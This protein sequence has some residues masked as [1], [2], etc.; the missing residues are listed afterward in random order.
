MK[1]IKSFF[2]IFLILLLSI[3]MFPGFYAVKCN[4]RVEYDVNT[5]NVKFNQFPLSYNKIS[6][7]LLEKQDKI[8]SRVNVWGDQTKFSKS[9]DLIA[10]YVKKNKNKLRPGDI[11]RVK[12]FDSTFLVYLGRDSNGQ[13]HLENMHQ[14]FKWSP[15]YFEKFYTGKTIE[16]RYNS[17]NENTRE[18]NIIIED[19]SLNT[20]H[21]DGGKRPQ[22]DHD[23]NNA[24]NEVL[25]AFRERP[26]RLEGACGACTERE[27]C[28]G[29]CRV[30][31]WAQNHSLVSED[32]FCS[33]RTPEPTADGCGN[34]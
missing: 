28:G 20:D 9:R 17:S 11:V 6:N 25:A 16:I 18:S 30:R 34:G 10:N 19:P 21:V 14:K 29:G 15:Q 33:V 7:E 22:S 4:E 1:Y 8:K 23:W 2:S 12:N 5:K 26:V 3:T 31:A 32:P 13:M 27:L 24:E